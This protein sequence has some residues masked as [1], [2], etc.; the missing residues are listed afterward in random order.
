[1]NEAT[2]STNL[3]PASTRP[4]EVQELTEHIRT[5]L[6]RSG[7]LGVISVSVLD[8][9]PV[10]SHGRWPSYEAVLDEITRYLHDYLTRKL[11]T[12]DR[13]FGPSANGNGFVILLDRP[14]EGRDLDPTDLA[15]V[16][17]R[18]RNGLRG[19]LCRELDEHVFTAFGCY[20][21]G[22]IM[23][24][25]AETPVER[26]V[27][28]AL[29]SAFADALS[30][31]ERDDRRGVVNL[32][33]VLETKQVK[34]V[35]QPVV[36]VVERRIVGY[37]AL[38]RVPRV[39]FPNPEELFKVAHE[40]QS[41]WQ[42][43]RLCRERA[44]DGVPALDPGQL[45]FLNVEPES[46]QDPELLGDAFVERLA[47]VGLAPTQVVFEITEHSAIRDYA[48]IRAHLAR[49]RDRGF[50]LAMDDVGSGYAGLQSIAEIAPDFLK[51]DM[52]LVRDVHRHTIKRELISTIRRFTDSTGIT[53]IAEGVES[54]HELGSLTAAGVRCAQGFLFARPAAPPD[55]PD[56]ATIEIATG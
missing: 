21:G 20:V 44:L 50:R 22:A 12:T 19:H 43:E 38:S 27:Y 10:D 9:H 51:V 26:I 18:L 14:R 36:D 32:Y 29:E 54:L 39:R 16:R 34:T 8:R 47:S 48:A 30:D 23:R 45:L 46:M 56:W 37:E 7:Q 5:E 13:L 6:A 11:R 2:P 42:L 24:H 3:T 28:R 4:P 15:R 55:L 52:S 35:Y 25:R 53:L 33:H 31:K 40:Q 41:L 49:A 17:L 1:M